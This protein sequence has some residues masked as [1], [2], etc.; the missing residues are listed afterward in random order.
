MKTKTLHLILLVTLLASACSSSAAAAN[1][2]VEPPVTQAA[3]I[4]P[5]VAQ[6]E[7]PITG[8]EPPAGEEP[9]QG[10][11]SDGRTPPQQAIEACD[12]KSEQQTC[13]FTAQKGAETG[14]CETVQNQLAC[15]P[16]RERPGEGQTGGEQAPS[17]LSERV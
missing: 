7:Q 15:S 10:Q 17:R 9:G 16:R 4:P 1:Q 6:D 12:G 2:T 3:E 5:T 11:P 13:E 14:V 8:Q